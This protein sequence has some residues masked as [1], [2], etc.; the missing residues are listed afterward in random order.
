MD[1]AL[2]VT[3]LVPTLGPEGQP[4]DEWHGAFGTGCAVRDDLILTSRH[5]IRPERRDRRFPIKVRWYDRRDPEDPRSAW[6]SLAGDDDEVIAWAGEGDLDAA[7]IRCPR[8]PGLKAVADYHLPVHRPVG[9][10]R[11]ESRGFPLAGV[12]EGESHPGDFIGEVMSMAL[13][14]SLFG[15]SSQVKTD[16]QADWDG[17]SGMPVIV[18][19]EILGV[20]KAVPDNY[21]NA[22]LQAVPTF[23]MRADE[24]FCRLL[25][26]ET[27]PDLLQTVHHLIVDLLKK[28]IRPPGNSNAISPPIAGISRLAAR[29]SPPWLSINPCANWSNWPW[30]PATNSRPPGM[31]RAPG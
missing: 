22:V 25:G 27:A 5:V 20:V 21:D 15:L 13:S 11:W 7:L 18:G 29:P 9:G 10:S 12:V 24:R 26:C 19:E 4:R 6:V 17:A 16:R 30:M 3:L 14:D 23:R 28:V 8:H 2:I 31:P 1:K